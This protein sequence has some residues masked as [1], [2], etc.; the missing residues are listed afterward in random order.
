ML[1]KFYSNSLWCKLHCFSP[2]RFTRMLG[3]R[4]QVSPVPSGSTLIFLTTPSST[5]I[6]YLKQNM[7]TIKC[8]ELSIYQFSRWRVVGLFYTSWIACSQ[9]PA[10][11]DHCQAKGQLPTKQQN[12]EWWVNNTRHFRIDGKV[13]LC[14]SSSGIRQHTNLRKESSLLFYI[15]KM[16]VFLIISIRNNLLQMS[17]IIWFGLTKMWHQCTK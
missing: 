11:P 2:Y 4:L 9:V 10:Q 16:V 8:H 3:A 5:N 6:E 12:K 7:T 13:Y 17:V 14:K 15:C 1:C